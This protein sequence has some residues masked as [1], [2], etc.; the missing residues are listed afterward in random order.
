MNDAIKLECLAVSYCFQ[1]TSDNSAPKL[2]IHVLHYLTGTM[3]FSG[4]GGGILSTVNINYVSPS[5]S[6][7]FAWNFVQENFRS[8]ARHQ[9][10]PDSDD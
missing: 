7:S 10:L 9:L 2:N 4:D 1:F 6:F 3:V 5:D 8:L